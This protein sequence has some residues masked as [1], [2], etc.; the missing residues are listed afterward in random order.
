MVSSQRKSSDNVATLLK[1]AVCILLN[2]VGEG[3]NGSYCEGLSEDDNVAVE[4]ALMHSNKINTAEDW[5]FV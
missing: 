4:S 3:K 1:S 5:H 2:F